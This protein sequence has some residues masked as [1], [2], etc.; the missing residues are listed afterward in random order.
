M[1]EDTEIIDL[2]RVRF[3]RA[4]A[5]LLRSI[6]KSG[7]SKNQTYAPLVR[8]YVRMGLTLHRYKIY[9]VEHLE[10]TLKRL[11]SQEYDTLKEELYVRLFRDLQLSTRKSRRKT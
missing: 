3:P 9:T 4:D 5:D 11:S 6:K 10:E 2:K 7:T 1:E 8:L